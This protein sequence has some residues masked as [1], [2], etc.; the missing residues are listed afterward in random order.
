M[1]QLQADPQDPW[2]GVEAVPA[3]KCAAFSRRSGANLLQPA[4][5]ETTA[6]KLTGRGCAAHGV[7]VSPHTNG[8]FTR[9]VCEACSEAVLLWPMLHMLHPCRRPAAAN[10]T[11]AL[12]APSG[13][14]PL[15]RP[16]AAVPAGV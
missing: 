1:L 5:G 8:E 16:R 4:G 2:R 9:G 15:S 10:F 3:N 7:S 12:L 11:F 14:D 13:R 6:K